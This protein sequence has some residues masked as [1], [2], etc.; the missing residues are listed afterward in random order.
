MNKVFFEN[1]SVK[2]K[3]KLEIAYI[4]TD[5]FGF[6]TQTN[7]RGIQDYIEQAL[8]VLLKQ[9]TKIKGASRT[10]SGVHALG[11]I[12]TFETKVTFNLDVFLASLNALLPR[13]I[14]IKNIAEV[15]SDF[16]PIY[17]AKAKLYRYCLWRGKCFNPFMDPY[18]W[19]VRRS[20]DIDCIRESLK[21][22][23]GRH[24]FSSF[25][26]SDSG[27]KT[28]VRSLIEVRLIENGE[29]IELWFLGEGFLKQMVRI[30]VGTLVD[31]AVKKMCSSN[32]EEILK[33]K[34]RHLSGQTAPARGLSLIEVYYEAV[35][36]IGDVVLKMRDKSFFLF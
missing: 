27:A 6:Q 23:V 30:L 3:Y 15:K 29:K 35:P 36:T 4:G 13:H 1:N 20:L 22:I 33:A 32:L 7:K 11:Q 5:F 8:G 16:D 19:N 12:A 28:R 34:N 21:I 26:N 14:G 2:R 9:P 10:D 25:C 17:H 24:D 18:V 31:L